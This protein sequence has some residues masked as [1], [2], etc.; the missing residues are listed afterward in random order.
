VNK[1]GVALE[2]DTV[3]IRNLPLQA[4]PAADAPGGMKWPAPAPLSCDEA[5]D[6]AVWLIKVTGHRPMFD[7]IS[8]ELE[9]PRKRSRRKRKAAEPSPVCER[10]GELGHV[11]GGETAGENCRLAL[12]ARV[13]RYD[14]DEEARRR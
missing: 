10:C 13:A 9:A 3:V 11:P 1:F 12:A 4:M 5:I 8:D 2:G 7:V 14:R 6:L